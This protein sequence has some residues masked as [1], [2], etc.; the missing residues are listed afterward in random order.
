MTPSSDTNSVTTSLPIVV[1]FCCGF[2]V[3]TDEESRT[4][5]VSRISRSSSAASAASASSLS[6]PLGLACDLDEVAAGVVEDG[7]RD[8]LQLERLL[9]EADAET[10]KSLGL[11][12][13]VVDGEGGE[14]NAVLDERLLERFRGGVR[15][16]LEKQLGSLP[17]LGGDDR[18]PARLAP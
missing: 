16:P 1:S 11:G 9:R 10:A 15:G 3:R 12:M 17:P 5:R 7:G 18:Q 6:S 2:S 8:A 13:D 4:H 14:G